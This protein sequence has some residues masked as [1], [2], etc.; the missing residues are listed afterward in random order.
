VLHH[1]WARRIAFALVLGTVVV[2]ARIR[3]DQLTEAHVPYVD[4]DTQIYVQIA[5]RPLGLDLLFCPKAMFVPLVYR[6]AHNDLPAIA[7]FQANLAFAAWAILTASVALALRR[8][9]AQGL[10]IG[11]GAAFLFAPPRVGFTASF[12]PESVNDSLTA[13]LAACLLGLVC[14]RGR[15]RIAVAVAVGG[16]G[17]LWMLTRDTNVFVAVAAVAVAMIVWRGWRHRWAWVVCGLVAAV[18]AVVLWS[19]GQPHERLPYQQAWY[20]RFTPRGAYPMVDNLV[21]RVYPDQRDELPPELRGFAEPHEQVWRLVE[22]HAEQRPLQDWL[23][24]HGAST[25]TR[26]L[27]RHPIDRFLELVGARWTVLAGPTNR[28][29]PVGWVPR[30]SVIGRLTRSRTLLWVLLLA[31]P[32]VLRKPRADVRLGVVLC[33][34]VSGLVGV[35]ASYYGDAAEVSR[36]CYGAG[37]QVVLGLFLALLVWLDRLAV[38][39]WR[40]GRPPVA[41]PAG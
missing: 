32:L 7:R 40:G 22:D 16:L 35:A 5:D 4:W 20:A 21:S 8:R 10:A 18:T 36:H 30:G 41:R 1:P 38:P 15:R 31:A 29:M 25:Y 12:L 17:L 24:D 6:A 27:L 39:R 9:W 11:M 33:V 14:L 2:A 28:Y 34:V 19:T 3:W 37:Q 26:W 23:V 13:L